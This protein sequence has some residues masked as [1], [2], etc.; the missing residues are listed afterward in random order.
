MQDSIT[1]YEPMR[2]WSARAGG[3]PTIT[4]DTARGWRLLVVGNRT[5]CSASLTESLGHAGFSV[6]SVEA[7][8][9]L[10]FVEGNLCDIVLLDGLGAELTMTSFQLCHEIRRRGSQVPVVFI[11]DD[12]TVAERL[13]AFDLGADDYLHQPIT[14]DEIERHLRAVL[15]RSSPAPHSDCLNGPG[16]I[17]LRPVERDVRVD[18]NSVR[19]TAKEFDLLRLLLQHR[20][21]PIA[22]DT[23]SWRVWGYETAGSRNFIEA[24]VSRLRG[25]LRAAGASDVITT[26][27]GFGYVIR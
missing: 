22:H 23:I 10:R 26:E 8:S 4:R 24:Q 13:L 7:S 5:A 27:R 19:L 9:A 14:P 18:G 16:G 11:A 2:S 3:L 25:K 6:H 21:R 17:E 12:D 20:G 1:S 15:R